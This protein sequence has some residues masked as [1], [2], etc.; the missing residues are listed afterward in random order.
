MRTSHSVRVGFP[1]KV[2]ERIISIDNKARSGGRARMVEGKRGSPYFFALTV[3]CVCGPGAPA[4]WN[5]SIPGIW[6]SER[7]Y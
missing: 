2:D 6:I 3:T 5:P 7:K 4:R 1:D